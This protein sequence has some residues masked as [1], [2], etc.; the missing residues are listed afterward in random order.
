MVPRKELQL[1]REKLGLSQQ[2]VANQAGISRPF[3]TNIE[4]GRK[5]PSLQVALRIAR[6][7]KCSV[8][9]FF[10]PNVP[11]RNRRGMK[12]TGTE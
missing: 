11:I 10:K 2:D 8:D 7:V 3:Y 4:L 9:I 6:A 5:N 1:A 12:P